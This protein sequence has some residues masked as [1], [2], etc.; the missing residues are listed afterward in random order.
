MSLVL[1]DS[2]IWIE[3]FRV[4]NSKISAEVDRLIDSGNIHTNELI[5]TELLPYLKQRKQ[6]Q[7][8]QI[9]E[10]IECFQMTIDWKQIIDFQT[11][12]LRN[13][14]NNVGIPDL[15]IAQN[16]LQNRATLF[17]LDKHFKLMSNFFKLSLHS[18]VTSYNDDLKF[19]QL[20]C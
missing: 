17:T 1:L 8:I 11:M 5:L 7:I 14:I 2:S 4:S 10:S 15:L 16:I 20:L 9:Q 6:T 13:G 3:Y 12:N 19:Y 18:Q